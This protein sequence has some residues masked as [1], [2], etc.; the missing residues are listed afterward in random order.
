[1]KRTIVTIF[2]TTAWIGFSE[3]VRNQ[4]IFLSYWQSHYEKLGLTFPAGA[5]NGAIW[6][7]WSF[8]FAVCIF[9]ISKKYSFKETALLAWVFGFVMMWVAIGNLG[10]LPYK[11]LWAA[12]PLSIFEAT[13]ATLIVKERSQL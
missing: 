7:M 3:F 13:I 4:L 9:I 6:G 11:I 2:L 10:V 12:V 5:L 8:I 1:M